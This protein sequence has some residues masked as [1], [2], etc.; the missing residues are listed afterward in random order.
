[1]GNET[2]RRVE[3]KD[4]KIFNVSS[5]SIKTASSEPAVWINPVS[6]SSVLAGVITGNNVLIKTGTSGSG[7]VTIGSGVTGVLDANNNKL[8]V[9]W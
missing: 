1:M 4:V 3:I 7:Y 5:N 6:A 9:A 2:E 8:T